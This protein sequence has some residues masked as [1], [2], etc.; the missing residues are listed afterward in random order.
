MAA[1]TKR[2]SG[3]EKLQQESGVSRHAGVRVGAAPGNG[4]LRGPAAG[5]AREGLG[6]QVGAGAARPPG[7]RSPAL[8]CAVNSR[9]WSRASESGQ[10]GSRTPSALRP[11]REP[12]EAG[13]EGDAGS[14]Q[15]SWGL[16]GET[17]GPEAFRAASQGTGRKNFRDNGNVL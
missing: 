12:A 10:G 16:Q 9:R 4:A 5:G 3:R 8:R 14:W 17:S 7:A 1:G 6:L 2:V 15:S 13:P 11:A